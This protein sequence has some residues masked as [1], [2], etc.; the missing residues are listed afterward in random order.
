MPRS[1]EKLPLSNRP[2]CKL[3][4]HKR[5]TD[6]P[7]SCADGAQTRSLR[8]PPRKKRLR[9]SSVCRSP[10]RPSPCWLEFENETFIP[11]HGEEAGQAHLMS[12]RRSTDQPQ[13]ASTVNARRHDRKNTEAGLTSCHS[14]AAMI[15]RVIRRTER[16]SPPRKLAAATS[17]TNLS[18]RG[19]QVTLRDG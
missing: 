15:T 6:E 7:A 2:R 18:R 8:A 3:C 16:R 9:S 11:G 17:S 4:R 13:V 10:F 19:R 12:H 1:L 14:A 5:I